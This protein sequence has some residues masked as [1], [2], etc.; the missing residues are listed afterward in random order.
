MR[1]KK[2]P[3]S[4]MPQILKLFAKVFLAGAFL[5]GISIASG[6]LFF[7]GN[8][9]WVVHAYTLLSFLSLSIGAMLLAFQ[10]GR[11]IV[12]ALSTMHFIAS[13]LGAVLHAVNPF[14]VVVLVTDVGVMWLA[15]HGMSERV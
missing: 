14:V 4:Y 8:G 10:R 13:M 6:D 2:M 11:K 1:R 7:W 9:S 3:S 15:W 5:L 12:F